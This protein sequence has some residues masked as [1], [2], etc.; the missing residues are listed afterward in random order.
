MNRAA[1]LALLLSAA[2][3]ALAAE[4]A[5]CPAPADLGATPYAAWTAADG[6]AAAPLARDLP[7]ALATTDGAASRGLRIDS[8]GKYG[9]AADSK[10]WIDV[11]ADGKPLTS[12]DHGHGPDCSGIRK[13]VWFDLAAGTYEVALSKAAGPSVRL[14]VVRA[15]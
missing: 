1:L 2:A 13:I 4:P 7:V 8:A 15:P 12:T 11:I 6:D 9:I 14:L 10:V 3:P 5:A